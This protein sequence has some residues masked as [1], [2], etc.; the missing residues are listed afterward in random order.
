MYER[1]LSHRST[2]A[3]NQRVRSISHREHESCHL[4]TLQRGL[5]CCRRSYSG[6]KWQ[7]W[8]ITWWYQVCLCNR[9]MLLVHVISWP[10]VTLLNNE[11]NVMM[12]SVFNT[13]ISIL[14]RYCLTSFRSMH[15]D[16]FM[17]L[18]SLI[19]TWQVFLTGVLYVTVEHPVLQSITKNYCAW[20]YALG[21]GIYNSSGLEQ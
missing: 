5:R 13:S 14:S 4:V 15:S 21:S 11:I 17:N 9:S 20:L 3:N 16:Y 6:A 18:I 7:Y 2:D 10:K 12:S 1:R 19:P 8:I